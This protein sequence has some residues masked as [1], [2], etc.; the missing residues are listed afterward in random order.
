MKKK[1][2]PHI[3]HE[4]HADHTQKH[5]KTRHS[6][7]S[8]TKKKK[9][10]LFYKITFSLLLIGFIA[11]FYFIVLVSTK[12]KSIS[13]VTQEIESVLQQKFGK[14]NVGLEN[15]YI[16]FTRYGTLKVVVTSLKILYGSTNAAEK[17]AFIIPKL[18]SEFSLLNFLLLHFQPS[19][20]KIINPLIVIDDLQKLQQQ[21]TEEILSQQSHL[22]LIV[23]LLSSI[24]KGDSPIKNF[25]I[26]N[27]K[28]LIKGEK[29]NTTVLLK[30]SQINTSIQDKILHIASVNRISF[31]E[32]KGDVDFN[33]NCQLS[34]QDGLKCD[35]VLENF[36]TDVISKLHPALSDLSKINAVLDATASFVIKDGEMSDLLFKVESEKGDFEFADFFGQKIDFSNLLVSGEYD[37][38]L[39]ILDLSSIQADFT[40]NV[41]SRGGNILV[42]HLA[43]SLLI[44][45]L[46]N[47]Q[48]KKLDF[49]I[50]IQNIFN[51]ELE[52]FW[53]TALHEKGIREWVISHTSGGVIKNAHA[54]FSLV[55]SQT[56]STITAMDSEV[57]FTNFD[58][59]Y[60]KSFPQITNVSGVARFTM[61]D[62]KISI[63]S[64][65]VLNSKISDGLV[66]IDDFNAP[67][68]MLKISGKSQG[69]AADTLKHA[70]NTADFANQIEK[71]LNGNSQN[72]FD[73]RL[74]ISHE[75]NLK[76]AFIAVNST[77]VGLD[78]DYVKG[79]VIINSKKDF[80]SVNFVTNVDLTMA[81]LTAKAFDIEKQSNVE[82]GLELIVSIPNS[83]KI[84]L[85]NI[86]LWKKEEV[87][88]EV[89][90]KI[91]NKKSAKNKA[92]T[93]KI[94]ADL[95]IETTP[96]LV[97]SVN[98]KNED[99]GKNNYAFSYAANK[100]TATQKISLKG[101]QFNLGALIAEK[102]FKNSSD[103]KDFTN[104]QIQ[105]AVNNIALLRNK[106]V[107]NFYLALNCHSG[108]CSNGILK[109]N[110][111]KKQFLN[112]HTEKDPQESSIAINGRITDIGYLAEGLGIANTISA[113][114]A[115]LKLQNKI[116]DKKPVLDGKITIDNDITIYDNPTVKR[117]AK[118]DLFSQI[119]DTIFSND[120][121]T[122]DSVSL[123]F[124]LQ[125]NTLNIKSLIANNYKI[126]ITAK[127][128]IDLK[129]NSYEIKG[130]IVPGFIINNLFGIGKIPLI[131]G[132]I[133]GLLTG[134]E[135]GGLFGLHYSYIKKPGDKEAKFDTN[136]VAAF[137]PSTIQNLFD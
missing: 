137:V 9:L 127:G 68:T 125:E 2:S 78:N 94:V 40:N 71:Y 21:P 106:S 76:T 48:N 41:S 115:K 73:I 25:E 102:F 19:K 13:F 109:G 100:K 38:K 70:D 20:I 117:L 61:N 58:L 23:G 65:D 111:G 103:N 134:G 66:A 35:V 17:K 120:K 33:S 16:S 3:D 42:P 81:E 97:T 45:N 135:G 123:E 8:K 27:A 62:M 54:K 119:K 53:P 46:D 113:G 15:S 95:E 43:M 22:S 132:V 126:G 82:S 59:E 85:K 77:I 105:V 75:I 92:V 107:K 88:K 51:D 121:T 83:Q 118:N 56:G 67:I 24:R 79:G 63:V 74:P 14:D 84:L 101:Q 98:F 130:M 90:N 69:H 124:S 114:D 29:F 49:S 87:A 64:G 28:L 10:P 7:K 80:G 26:E 60:D 128:V 136:K 32:A 57:A 31:D 36:A 96:F 11:L 18:E 91:A 37:N 133:S 86:S 12:P 5:K 52:K 93:A 47:E 89:S 108:L 55:Q 30:K 34:K 50:K 104:F 39:K 116:V 131:G 6:H 122:F 4:D 44:S 112:L 1:K 129:Q 110:Y 72:D 99:F